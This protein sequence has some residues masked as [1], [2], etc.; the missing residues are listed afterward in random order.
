MA[1]RLTKRCPSPFHE[2]EREVSVEN[3]SPR[4]DSTTGLKSWCKPCRSRQYR[5]NPRVR[6]AQTLRSRRWNEENGEEQKRRKRETY[7]SRRKKPLATP[8]ERREYYRRWVA[9][10][11]DRVA[12]SRKKWRDNNRAYVRTHRLIRRAKGTQTNLNKQKFQQRWDYYG[13]KC[14]LCGN[15]AVEMD[16]VKPISRGGCSLASNLRP[17]CRSCNRRKGNLWPLNLV[18]EK[19][20]S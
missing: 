11:H 4:K 9:A 14:W 8:E 5:E 3:F 19:L 20:A 18:L 10:N 7:V 16:H 12:A 1:A 15:E 2:G 17:A 13:G 6:E